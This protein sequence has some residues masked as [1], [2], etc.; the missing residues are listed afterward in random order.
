MDFWQEFWR[1]VVTVLGSGAVFGFVQFLISRHD[2]KNDKQE[3][4]LKRI[5]KLQ[6]ELAEKSARDARMNILR[7]DEELM[8]KMHHSKD[9]FRTILDDI[10]RYEQYCHA[11]PNFKNSYA[12]AA[13]SH[14]ND[15]YKELL[16]NCSFE[17]KD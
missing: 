14:I 11:H 15:T 2:K 13:I 17:V 16:R 4:I 1:I 7:F 12:A 10:D 8:A 9:Y 3:E 6:N 5:G